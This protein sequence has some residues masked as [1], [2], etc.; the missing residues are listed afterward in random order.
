M[1]TRKRS[2]PRLL[3]DDLVSTD[4][5]VSV[6][7]LSALKDY[8]EVTHSEDDEQIEGHLATARDLFGRLSGHRINEETRRALFDRASEVYEMPSRPVNA[9]T[10]FE[11]LDEGTA[12]ALD[13]DHVYTYGTDAP[14]VRT[15]RAFAF[16]GPLDAVRF[17]YTAGYTSP[18]EVPDGIVEVLKKMV[19][20]LYEFRT[21]V[22]QEGN[23]PRELVM[24]WK[25]ISTPYSIIKF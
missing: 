13:I 5:E 20:D 15:K 19:S 24:T 21:S 11:K 8:L 1:L 22:H 2:A 4:T 10:G 16:S 25:E 7:S 14:E 3:S 23:I 12:T 17:E 18:S 9:V 6:L